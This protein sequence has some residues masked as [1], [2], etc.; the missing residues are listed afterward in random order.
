MS[1]GDGDQERRI[2]EI[3]REELERARSA[4]AVEQLAALQLE[5]LRR[6][7]EA[8]RALVRLGLLGRM[9]GLYYAP[10]PQGPD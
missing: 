8:E 2:R 3:V 5:I 6:Q 10:L 9:P 4:S 7:E 1:A